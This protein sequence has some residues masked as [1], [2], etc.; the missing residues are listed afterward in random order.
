MAKVKFFS[1]YPKLLGTKE[2]DVDA[3]NV[4]ELLK[5]LEAQFGE[6]FKKH[7]GVSKVIVNGDNVGLKKGHKTP[8]KADDQVVIVPPIAGG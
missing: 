4:G 7:I 8:L 3:A 1:F 5:K 6:S 2:T